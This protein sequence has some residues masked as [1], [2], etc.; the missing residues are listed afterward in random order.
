MPHGTLSTYLPKFVSTI[1]QQ[2][3]L[4]CKALLFHIAE[5]K[6]CGHELLRLHSISKPTWEDGF[7]RVLGQRIL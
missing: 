1:E 4:D 2:L 3:L 6:N 5:R 7:I